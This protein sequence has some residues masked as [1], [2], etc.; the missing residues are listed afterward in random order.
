MELTDDKIRE[1][2]RQHVNE[3]REHI[4]ELHLT[5]P[6]CPER[7][8]ANFEAAVIL[9]SEHNDNLK[10]SE[11]DKTTRN[12]AQDLLVNAGIN[13]PTKSLEFKKLCRELTRAYVELN[14]YALSLAEGRD[15]TREK[16]H[17]ATPKTITTEQQ[18]GSQTVSAKPI[19]H[20]T[21]SWLDS[22]KASKNIKEKS[23]TE[24]RTAVR[25]LTYIIGDIEA[26]RVNY[27]KACEFRD[28]LKK[29]P[30]HRNK[31]KAYRDKNKEELLALNVP[32]RECISG[33]T[34]DEKLTTL[35]SFFNWLKAKEVVERNP[36]DEVTITYESESYPP[37][38][39]KD[40]EAIFN[41]PLYMDS[42]YSRLATTT[43]SHWWLPL[44]ALY[45]GA[46]VSELIQMRLEDVKTIEGFLT[47]TVK[48][49]KE[50]DQEVKTKAGKRTF[51]IHP[52]LLELGFKQYIDQLSK[53]QQERVFPGF[54][55]G[56][57]TKG[58]YASKW[59]GRYK[60]KLPPSFKAEGKVLHSFRHTF[61]TNALNSRTDLRHLQ[62]MVGHEKG[63]SELMGATK[64]YDH[65]DT[66]QALFESIKKLDFN[67]L[68]LNHLTNGWKKHNLYR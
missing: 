22:L 59:Y 4:E 68:D 63:Y 33:S 47:A 52:Q 31:I 32:P 21:E 60:E 42:P 6:L 25:D 46:R 49:D 11:F 10:R 24:Y 55:L 34:I 58:E 51:P 9:R 1:L 8:T 50:H 29:I 38:T 20:Y 23:L 54:Q 26:S 36:F 14:T 57:R 13:I 18:T 67:G 17:I 64:I 40:L 2:V 41:S 12:H 65:G 45:S 53:A 66:T 43:A 16:S 3:T 48:E 28:T 39:H 27:D 44:V 35:K 61:I 5:N 56:T 19:S 7:N 15:M 62:Q 30:K 37:Y